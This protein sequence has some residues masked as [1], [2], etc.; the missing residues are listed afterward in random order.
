MPRRRA[1]F[2]PGNSARLTPPAVEALLDPA[3]DSRSTAR[4]TVDY[5]LTRAR[6]MG[7]EPSANVMHLYNLYADGHLTPAELN[8][9]FIRLHKLDSLPR[10]D[11]P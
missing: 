8:A 1:Q 10:Q 3:F 5:A 7:V 2:N 9:A 6:A 4:E 11:A